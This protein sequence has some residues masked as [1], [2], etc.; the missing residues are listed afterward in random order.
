M[1][2]HRVGAFHHFDAWVLAA[3]FKRHSFV[4]FTYTFFPPLK[5]TTSSTFVQLHDRKHWV[6]LHGL[7]NGQ[8]QRHRCAWENVEST[9]RRPPCCRLFSPTLLWG[10]CLW[11]WCLWGWC[12]DPDEK[13]FLLCPPAEWRAVRCTQK[14]TLKRLFYHLLILN[15]DWEKTNHYASWSGLSYI[16]LNASDVSVQAP[17]KSKHASCNK[18]PPQLYLGLCGL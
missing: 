14:N 3:L 7:C 2:S 8:E 10:W 15:S 13:L 12:Q 18:F 6:A 16:R 11:G 4:L 9:L 5:L 17:H 1:W